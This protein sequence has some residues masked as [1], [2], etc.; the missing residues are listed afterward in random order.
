MT[1]RREGDLSGGQQQ[2]LAMARAMIMQPK[3]LL[4]DKPTEGI[5]P[6][7]I[8]QIGRVI[9]L[10]RAKGDMAIVLIEQYFDFA[11][12]LADAFYVLKRGRG[13]CRAA[14]PICRAIN[15]GRVWR[16]DPAGKPPKGWTDGAGIRAGCRLSCCRSACRPERQ[17]SAPP[18]W[19][20]CHAG[21]G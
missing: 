9:A 3:V 18:P 4:P 19:H 20:R 17:G 2:Q 13:R 6:N 15:C 8:Q 11:Y 16:S 14:R 10:L 7:I 21:T 5:Q 1:A 12:D